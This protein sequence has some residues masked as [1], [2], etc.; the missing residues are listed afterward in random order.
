MLL[1]SSCIP[2]D[3]RSRRCFRITHALRNTRDRQQLPGIG[4]HKLRAIRS[5]PVDQQHDLAL[6]S[7]AN[8][9]LSPADP[10]EPVDPAEQRQRLIGAV[11]EALER[12]A[13]LGRPPRRPRLSQP[14]GRRA[15]GGSAM[16]AGR[17]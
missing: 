3:A 16:G 2:S 4:I 1:T 12:G 17:G 8:D 15:T 13:C 6:S 11:A 10:D 7:A 9:E 14:T 5:V